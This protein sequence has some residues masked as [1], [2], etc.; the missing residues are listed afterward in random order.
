PMEM[1][2]ESVSVKIRRSWHNTVIAFGSNL[3]DR[4][5]Y[6]ENAIREIEENS[7]IKDIKV[8]SFIETEPYGYTEQ[9]DFLNG[10]L[11]CRT[12]LSP[13]KLLEFLHT[14]ENEAGRTR[15][16][17]W[18]ART[19]DL[20]IIF[21][22]DKII[23]TPALTVPHIDMCNRYFVLKPVSEIVPYYRHPVFNMTVIQLLERLE[24]ND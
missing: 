7:A 6:I 17:H 14:I 23:D 15:K 1:D 10:A 2:F 18:G 8:S 24:R 13:E 20:D 5:A 21:Y 11:I 22:D 9:P 16:V 19:L 4:K 12:Y 3:G